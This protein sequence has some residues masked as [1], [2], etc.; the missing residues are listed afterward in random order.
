MINPFI[1][2]TRVSWRCVARGRRR[3]SPGTPRTA[4][5]HPPYNIFI[6]QRRPTTGAMP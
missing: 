5:A 4:L 2:V 3:T 1:A 6:H